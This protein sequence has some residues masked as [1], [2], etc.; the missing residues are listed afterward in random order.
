MF[1]REVKLPATV[2]AATIE[3]FATRVLYSS[4]LLLEYSIRVLYYWSTLFEYFATRVLDSS[5][6][7][8][9][10]SIRVLCYSSTR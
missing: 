1:S 6:L 2:R 5:T 4:T 10:Y 8:L 7:L 3:Y 9:E